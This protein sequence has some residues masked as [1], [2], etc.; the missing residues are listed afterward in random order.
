MSHL[1]ARKDFGYTIEPIQLTD[2]II[3]DIDIVD[4]IEYNKVLYI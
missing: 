3:G 4:Y 2:I 1:I